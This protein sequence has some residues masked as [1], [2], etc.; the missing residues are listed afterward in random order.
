[1]KPEAEAA[2]ERD[3]GTVSGEAKKHQQRDEKGYLYSCHAT[4]V[5]CISKGNARAPCEFG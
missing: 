5:E 4:A 1:M 2:G 3:A